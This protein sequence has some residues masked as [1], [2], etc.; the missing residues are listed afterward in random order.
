MRQVMAADEF[1]DWS[2]KF[3]S[4]DPAGLQ[5]PTVAD[6][7]DPKQSHLDGLC[8]SRAWCLR[9]LGYAQA[10][11][12]HL[13]A[14]LRQATGGEYVGEHWLASFAALALGDNP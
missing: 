12:R 4:T 5:L 7:G 11:Q 13:E 8:L 9:K 2:G 1:R 10:A 6:R 14:G 3:L